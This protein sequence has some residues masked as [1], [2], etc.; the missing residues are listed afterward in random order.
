VRRRSAIQSVLLATYENAHKKV[1]LWW[2][3]ESGSCFVSEQ[4][5]DAGRGYI[6][7]SVLSFS[8][9][10]AART[11]YDVACVGAE[12]LEK[13]DTPTTLAGGAR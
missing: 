4:W 8:N 10:A 7:F 9:F 2:E 11:K 13:F 3:R 6:E 1:T 5:T 12:L